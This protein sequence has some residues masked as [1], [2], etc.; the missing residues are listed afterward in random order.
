MQSDTPHSTTSP[1][2]HA[3]GSGGRREAGLPIRLTEDMT[4]QQAGPPPLLFGTSCWGLLFFALSGEHGWGST[5]KTLSGSSQSLPTGGDE[6]S[7]TRGQAHE[8]DG[9]EHSGRHDDQKPTAQKTTGTERQ[10]AFAN[11]ERMNMMKECSRRYEVWGDTRRTSTRPKP[12]TLHRLSIAA[13]C[14]V[15]KRPS[16][17]PVGPPGINNVSVGYR[18]TLLYFG[19]ANTTHSQTGGRAGGTRSHQRTCG[20]VESPELKA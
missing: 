10:R 9:C 13:P 17:T 12:S 16:G 4:F 19:N 5:D 14:L 8:H 11:D 15:S 1:T 6:R 20:F 18:Y 2:K 7:P 3:A